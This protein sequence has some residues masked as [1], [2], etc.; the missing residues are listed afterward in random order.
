M[1]TILLGLML[2]STSVF[3]DEEG[4]FDILQLP[5]GASVTLPS[6]A[7]TLVPISTSYRLNPTDKAQVF[8]ISSPPSACAVKIEFYDKTS[9]EVKVA[10]LKGGENVIYRFERF[11]GVRVH[12]SPLSKCTTLTKLVLDSNRPLEIGM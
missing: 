12:A 1:R 3:A 11:N 6:P 4:V 5:E 10:T 8:R 9:D 7:T 2:I